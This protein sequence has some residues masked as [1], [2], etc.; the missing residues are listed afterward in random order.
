MFESFRASR[1]FRKLIRSWI[2]YR[3]LI[4][5]FE[6]AKGVTDGHEKRF[7]ALKAR[8]A[9]LLPAVS[10]RAPGS[11]E[12]EAQRQT[13]LMTALL[14]RHRTLRL[15]EPVSDSAREEFSRSWHEHYIFLN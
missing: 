7:L 6:G 1:R 12:R 8:I 11:M 4:E 2:E 14:N 3:D 13:M 5:R 9:S 15:E 10:V